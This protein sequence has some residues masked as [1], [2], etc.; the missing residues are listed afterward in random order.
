LNVE[1]KDDKGTWVLVKNQFV[2]PPFPQGNDPVTKAHFAEYLLFFDSVQTRGIRITGGVGNAK[3][4]I[5]DV[6]LFTSIS[7]LSVYAPM[8]GRSLLR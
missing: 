7:E 8:H 3:G 2:Y 5:K 4:R 1:Y 6:P